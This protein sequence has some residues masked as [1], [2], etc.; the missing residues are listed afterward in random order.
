MAITFGNYTSQGVLVAYRIGGLDWSFTNITASATHLFVSPD[1][2]GANLTYP[3]NPTTFELR[4]TNWAYGIHIDSVHVASGEN[5]VK[6]PD[7]DR[8]VEFIGDSLTSGMYATYEAFS[9]FGYGIGAG[10]GNTEFSIT[11]YPGIC[12]TDQECWGNPRG[13]VHQWFYTSDTSWRAQQMYG[14]K[15]QFHFVQLTSR[16]R[17]N[18]KK[19]SPHLRNRGR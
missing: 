12:A 13:Q 6:I 9:G 16:W 14:G 1:T 3:I 15:W 17:V 7:Y 18:G 4:V 5:L 10:L 19:C 2:P 11:A 8:T